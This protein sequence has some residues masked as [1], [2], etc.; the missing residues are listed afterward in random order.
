MKKDRL[1]QLKKQ[2][3][4]NDQIIQ[5]GLMKIYR[6]Q[7][8]SLPDIS[9]LEIKSRK[10]GSLIFIGFLIVVLM[11]A[12]AAWLGFLIFNSDGNFGAK[13]IKLAFSGPQSIASG[14]EVT[15]V[16]EYKSVEKVP[17]QNVEIIFRYPD[18]FEFISAEPLP[19]NNFNSSW[20]IGELAIGQ[21]DKIQIKGKIIGE[22]GSVKTIY[23]TASYQPQNFSSAFKETQSFSSQITSSILAIDLTGPS[24]ILPQKKGSYKITYKN[25]SEQ[26]LKNVKILAVYPSNFIFQESSLKPYAKPEEARNLNNQ[27][28]IQNLAKEEE[29]EI[30]ILGGYLADQNQNTAEFKIQIGF[31][32]EK[33]E[34]F[35]LQQEKTLTT[36]IIRANLSLNLIINGSS[37]SQPIS[38]DQELTY[39][40]VY[41]NLGQQDLDDLILFV[42]L[43]SP[44][45]DWTSLEDKHGGIVESNKITWTKDQISEFDLISPLAE[46]TIDFSIKT[47]G[48]AQLNLEKDNLSIKSKATAKIA[49][50][51]EL[52]S[53]ELEVSSNEIIN[54]INTD[55]E[56]RV[57]GRYFDDDNIAVG[58]GPLPPVVGEKTTFRIYWS[59]A[60]SLFE[61]SDVKVTTRLPE[62]VDWADK[63]LVKVG[64]INYSSKN[65]EISWTINRL[66]PNKNFDD[67][68]V[69]F[70]VFVIPTKNQVRKLLILTDQTDLTATDKSTNAQITKTGKA[71]TSNL[72]DDPIGGGK[73]LVID[74]TE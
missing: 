64:E 42:T 15:Y 66:P 59:I 37:Q 34:I 65:R 62:G 47:K 57:E 23:A 68:N 3:E 35:S 73:G 18:G 17:L 54:N 58:T 49:K 4:D 28:L 19:T 72:E 25:N 36:E 67:I 13:S 74:I 60:N 45:L 70:D 2:A 53:D 61:V 9:H 39:S 5:K 71:I 44:A 12:G 1:K 48:A 69:W 21:S 20:Q 8:G 14:D 38:F 26:E 40:I 63:F 50:I 30:E 41:K 43:D 7:D 27:W 10:R 22:V 11:L 52:A 29:G 24:Q 33:N 16:L 32:D 46:K 31:W 51:G 56:L 6:N 55:I